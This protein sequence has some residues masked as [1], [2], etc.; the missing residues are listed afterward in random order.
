MATSPKTL[1]DNLGL[2]ASVVFSVKYFE[3]GTKCSYIY[4][5]RLIGKVTVKLIRSMVSLIYHNASCIGNSQASSSLCV[6]GLSSLS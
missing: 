3:N 5:G 1:S 6:C 2:K 4:S